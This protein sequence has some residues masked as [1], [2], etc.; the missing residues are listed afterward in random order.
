M[1]PD[2]RPRLLAHNARVKDAALERLLAD[3]RGGQGLAM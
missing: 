2:L 3:A 1:I